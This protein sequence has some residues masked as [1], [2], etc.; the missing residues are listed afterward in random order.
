MHRFH[1]FELIVKI[2]MQKFG[3]RIHP[4]ESLKRFISENIRPNLQ[5]KALSGAKT[6]QEV[7]KNMFFVDEKVCKLLFLNQFGLKK[8]YD[9]IASS[10]P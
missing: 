8:I 9:T 3:Q 2:S 5:S 4:H 1:F 10:V 7:L 6:P